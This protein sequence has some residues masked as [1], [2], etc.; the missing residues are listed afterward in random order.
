MTNDKANQIIDKF[1]EVTELPYKVGETIYYCVREGNS[2]YIR[3]HKDTINSVVKSSSEGIAYE[4]EADFLNF[5]V[6]ESGF[7]IPMVFKNFDTAK[8]FAE[9]LAEKLNLEVIAFS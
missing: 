1:D 3:V 5:N 2:R 9:K 6:S 4:I 7:P 8:H